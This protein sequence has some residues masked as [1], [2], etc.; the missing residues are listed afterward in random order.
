MLICIILYGCRYICI[1]IAIIE[2]TLFTFHTK[3]VLNLSVQL[4]TTIN[5]LFNTE[6]SEIIYY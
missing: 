1:L 2:F 3:G 4:G 6:M 5:V